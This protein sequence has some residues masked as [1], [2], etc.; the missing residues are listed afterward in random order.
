MEWKFSRARMWLEWIDKGNTMPAPI[1]IAYYILYLIVVLLCGKC[2][3]RVK[4]KCPCCEV[5]KVR[6]QYGVLYV[7]SHADTTGFYRVKVFI[8]RSG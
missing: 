1:N 4:E 2:L 7:L 5:N 6:N 3:G 8:T